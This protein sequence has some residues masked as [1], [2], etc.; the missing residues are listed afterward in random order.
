MRL[1]VPLYGETLKSVS[2]CS[3]HLF[4]IYITGT[5]M[6]SD[7]FFKS[8]SALWL[9]ISCQKYISTFLL[10]I[11]KLCHMRIE[12]FDKIHFKFQVYE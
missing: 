10:K 12:I 6:S 1:M 7:E 9:I 4:Y 8:N 5:R 11:L 2:S 3:T